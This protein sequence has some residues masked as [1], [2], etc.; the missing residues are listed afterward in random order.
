MESFLLTR[1]GNM[2]VGS[3]ELD[4]ESVFGEP[5]DEEDADEGRVVEEE[6]KSRDYETDGDELSDED[7]VK[8]ITALINLTEAS[9]VE[10]RRNSEESWDRFNGKFDFSHRKAWQSKEVPPKVHDIVEKS[11]ASATVPF[12]MVKEWFDAEVGE[13]DKDLRPIITRAVRYHLRE[14]EFV[15][16]FKTAFKVSLLSS[17]MVI[18]VSWTEK[19]KTIIENKQFNSDYKEGVLDLEVIDPDKLIIDPT[20]KGEWLILERE[21]YFGDFMKMVK[22][23]TYD[24]KEAILKKKDELLGASVTADVPAT[25]YGYSTQKE[26]E[27]KNQNVPLDT[28]LKQVK[29][30]EFW[31]NLYDQES[32][33]LIMENCTCILVNNTYVL[34]RPTPNPN[35]HQMIPIVMC[36]LQEVPF[37][38]Y[39]K[40]PVSSSLG[41]I[42]IYI[43]FFNTLVDAITVASIPQFF[44]NIDNLEDGYSQAYTG[45]YPGKTWLGR[46]EARRDDTIS[47]IPLAGPNPQSFSLLELV[48]REIQM[49]T[50][51]PTSQWGVQKTRGRMTAREA[52]QNAAN[53]DA[54]FTALAD[55]ID[56]H[57]LTP[58]MKLIYMTVLEHQP[59]YPDESFASTV[60]GDNKKVNEFIKG[61]ADTRREML[62]A[63]VNFKVKVMSGYI[64]KQ[65]ELE[66]LTSFTRSLVEFLQIPGVMEDMQKPD[67]NG[68]IM[69]IKFGNI[70]K[71]LMQIYDA[72]TE[73]FYEEVSAT[74]QEQGPDL[75]TQQMGNQMQD[76]NNMK[77]LSA[78]SIEGSSGSMEDDMVLRQILNEKSQ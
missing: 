15:N 60:F 1:D 42:N 44:A 7:I 38:A 65:K 59:L 35:K 32:G 75:M 69:R 21:Y 22:A 78:P 48:D 30:Q 41:M 2:V 64:S 73:D 53:V 27:K 34:Q 17:L 18:K 16:K 13:A 57:F 6:G 8:N 72:D 11:A 33:E 40:S 29:V 51:L 46:G 39:H 31:G 71:K 68:M 4:I 24:N 20:G 23:G 54:F 14:S 28:T 52:V 61:N 19:R 74:P 25:G 56:S 37:S 63:N 26:F 58:L 9:V 55:H 36:G 12:S 76:M 67:S 62:A 45:M 49:S 3:E 50:A 66:K 43:E 70:F 5:F 77:A 47:E 10:H